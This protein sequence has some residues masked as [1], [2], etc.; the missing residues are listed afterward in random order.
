MDAASSGRPAVRTAALVAGA[1]LVSLAL[2]I[3]VARDLLASDPLVQIP[4]LDDRE[5]IDMARAMAEGRAE[6]WFFAPLYPWLLSFTV[7]LLEQAMP[8]ACLTN[9]VL[10]ATATATAAAAGT[11]MHSRMAGVIAA[12]LHG[13]A[14]VFLFHDA[15]PGQESALALLHLVALL[16]AV[17]L[18]RDARPWTAL[19][20]GA[21]AGVA[22][23]GR[24]TSAALVLLAVPAIAARVPRQRWRIAALCAAGLASV[25]V[26][27]AIRNASVAGDFSPLP[28]ARGPNLYAANGP[29]AR[30]TTSFYSSEL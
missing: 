13:L 18:T 10:G 14:G 17:R 2:R 9:A 19:L 11:A 21:V 16:L 29:D 27:A 22:V 1:F 23:L 7:R 30:A 24:G 8:L 5:Y 25:L 3:A 12:C 20:L 28:W 4:V 6:P 15:L 26:P